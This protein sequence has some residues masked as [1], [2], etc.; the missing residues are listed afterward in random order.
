MS[1]RFEK[2][3]DFE[4]KLLEGIKKNVKGRSKFCIYNAIHHLKMAFKIKNLDPEMALFRAITAEEE[5][6]RAI[7]IILKDQS[8]LMQT[9]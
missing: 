6:S 4:R 1:E 8:I 5:V 3:T 7:F 2:L 9:K